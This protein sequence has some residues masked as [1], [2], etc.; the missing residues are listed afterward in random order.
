MAGDVLFFCNSTFYIVSREIRY[1]LQSENEH[2]IAA[3]DYDPIVLNILEA[4][5]IPKT[6]TELE[7]LL[8]LNKKLLLEYVE[9]LLQLQLLLT[10][11]HQNIIGPDYFTRIDHTPTDNSD[12]YL[13]TER[14][15]ISGQLN[16]KVFRHLPDLALKMQ[17]L[18]EGSES[19]ELKEFKERFIR[20]FEQAEVPLMV[21]LARL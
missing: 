14:K 13:I 2:Q 21:A 4:C 11:K 5:C 6:F 18:K 17:Q 12:H 1:I 10:S 9:D 7:N 20:K 19:S 8:R 16:Q 3:I 15:V